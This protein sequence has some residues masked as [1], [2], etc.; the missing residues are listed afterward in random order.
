[1]KSQF[2]IINDRNAEAKNTI[3]EMLSHC[4]LHGSNNGYAVNSLPMDNLCVQFRLLQTKANS[5]LTQNQTWTAMNVARLNDQLYQYKSKL[6]E[7][8]QKKNKLEHSATP[9]NEEQVQQMRSLRKQLRG[10][11]VALILVLIGELIMTSQAFMVY[12]SSRIGSYLLGLTFTIATTF[13]YLLIHKPVE[14]ITSPL[15]KRT[16]IAVELLL[17]AAAI[18]VTVLFRTTY[19]QTVHNSGA[20]TISLLILTL[21]FNLVAFLILHYRI[22]PGM[23][24][25][26]ELGH[27]MPSLKS[28]KKEK[29]ELQQIT[30]DIERL[31]QEKN[32][33]EALKKE[34]EELAPAIEQ[35]IYH[36]GYLEGCA[37]WKFEYMLTR[38]VVPE[39]FS[40]VEPY[41]LTFYYITVQQQNN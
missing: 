27:S 10:N 40:I 15:L 26:Q 32:E 2:A 3:Q 5:L 30:K 35:R 24:K 9:A 25:M 7:A 11:F 18:V 34:I 21:F 37:K 19:F 14:N 16:V 13:A 8:H 29:K 41:P 1:M 6:A 33:A 28:I 23:E 20:N 4:T 31:T 22:K 12:E 38:G 17:I 39:S 36:E